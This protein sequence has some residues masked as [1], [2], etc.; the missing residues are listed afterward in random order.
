MTD[1]R[2]ML[3]WAVFGAVAAA[4]MRPAAAA[5]SVAATPGAL[6]P[7]TPD[8]LSSTGLISVQSGRTL[9]LGW[10]LVSAA[11]PTSGAITLHLAHD[12][13][14][15]VR[16]DLCLREGSARGPAAT[17]F[18]DFIVMDGGNGTAPVDEALG[19]A[20]RVLAA[21]LEEVEALHLTELSLLEPHADRTWRY[22]DA[23]G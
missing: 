8:N 22:P 12:D 16:V 5:D 11:P 18:V 13:G 14:R 15:G 9:G 4:V 3:Q 23:L 20:L 1:R 2:E 21:E 10:A 17:E 7:K 6:S 19:R